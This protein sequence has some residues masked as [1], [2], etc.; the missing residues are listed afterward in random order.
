MHFLCLVVAP[1]HRC[2]CRRPPRPC[3]HRRTNTLEHLIIVLARNKYS[4]KHILIRDPFLNMYVSIAKFGFELLGPERIFDA[5][6]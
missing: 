1:L 6:E 3:R 2:R 5:S 4:L